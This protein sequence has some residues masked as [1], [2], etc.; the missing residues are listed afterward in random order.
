MGVNSGPRAT[1]SCG[2]EKRSVREDRTLEIN[3]IE[4]NVV[5]AKRTLECQDLKV[6]E[7][8]QAL[9]VAADHASVS[10]SER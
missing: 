4:L 3:E 6:Q 5:D 1:L 8:Q 2:R 9:V 10:W 7:M